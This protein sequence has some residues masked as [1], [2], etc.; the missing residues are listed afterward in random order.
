MQSNSGMMEW[1]KVTDL[2]A[3][4]LRKSL[5]RHRQRSPSVAKA[6][7]PGDSAL[8]SKDTGLRGARKPRD[9]KPS[10]RRRLKYFYW[11][12]VRLR[13]QPEALARG[14]A[15][16]VFAGL[17]P[18]FGSQTLLAVLLAFLFRGNKILALVGPWISNPFTSVP[19]YAFNFY[20][21][22]WLINDHTPT[23]INWHSWEDIKELG[24]EIIWPLFIGCVVVG[25]V[26]AII[27]Y[28]LGLWLIRRVRASHHAR[29]RSR[30][31]EH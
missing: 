29:P 8:A 6:G 4:K 24:I 22:K 5:Q 20:V 14:I 19:I 11:L 27:S 15:C 21:G 10:W 31:L 13:G 28:F 7:S 30:R 1:W 16:G 9:S 18:F 17:F 3:K 2:F 25:L 26:C 23:D 12:L